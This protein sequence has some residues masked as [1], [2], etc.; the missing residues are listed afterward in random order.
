MT[1]G[2]SDNL[3]QGTVNVAQ[4]RLICRIVAHRPLAPKTGAPTVGA[5]TWQP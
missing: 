3:A 2:V 5:L 1:T 4:S